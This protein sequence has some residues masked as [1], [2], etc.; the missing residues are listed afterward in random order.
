MS[1]QDYLDL[2]QF[3]FVIENVF[4]N[5]LFE[6]FFRYATTLGVSKFDYLLRIF[7]NISK[8]PK[9]IVEIFDAFAEETKSEL[10]D[11]DS[12]LVQY[13]QKDEN[14][15]KLIRGDAGGNLIYKYKAMGL[16]TAINEW[17][18]YLSNLLE[19]I[20]N[21]KLEKYIKEY[22]RWQPEFFCPRE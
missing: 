20:V 14:Y 21:E 5:Q 9:K 8:A 22:P 7:N 1:F 16:A 15:Q 13:Y 11:S 12:E 17:T 19:D 18:Q 2:R 3:A 6:V 10:W 4:N